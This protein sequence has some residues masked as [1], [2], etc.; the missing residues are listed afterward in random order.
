PYEAPL[1]YNAKYPSNPY[2][3]EVYYADAIV[4]DFLER[5][6]KKNGRRW[7]VIITGDHG[8]GLGDNI[9]QTHGLLL[10]KKTRVVPL[11]IYDSHKK[12]RKVGKGIK[13][14]IDIAP[15]ISDILG[16]EFSCDGESVFNDT[17]QRAVF[18]ETLV[19]F[20]TY[21]IN[22]AFS[23]KK[24]EKIYIRNGMSEEIFLNNN[25]KDNQIFS[26]KEFLGLARKAVDAFFN[27]SELKENLKLSN[28]DIKNLRSLG[29][30]G[31]TNLIFKK[32]IK[33]DLKEFVKDEIR[34]ESGRELLQRGKYYESL[35]YYE[36]FIK[37]YP[38]ASII[39]LE[40]AIILYNIGKI[41]EAKEA[42]KISLLLDPKNSAAYI[43]LG[44]IYIMEKNYKKAEESFLMCLKLEE[45][46]EAFLNLG[47][48]YH[49]YLSDKSKAKFYLKTFIAK[50]PNDPEKEKIE[51]LLA[52]IESEK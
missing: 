19:P 12:L 28:E 47:L 10:Y 39:L 4:G 27:E 1:Q 37:K 40:K 11:V 38:Y 41:K 8:E 44:N 42:I 2:A 48:L 9:E 52:E 49:Y 7:I 25:E 33:C 31:N 35:P 21:N 43:N 16:I 46:T 14:L 29:Y 24:N 30:I 5:V 45:E 26:Q 15:T 36:E 18:S 6:L 51:R 50:A 23:F 17:E 13:S 34:L 3:G 32:S 20:T 22:G